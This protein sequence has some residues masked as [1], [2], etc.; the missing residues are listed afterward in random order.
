MNPRSYYLSLELRD[1]T[2]IPFKPASE[3]DK[4]DIQEGQIILDYGCGIGSFTLP[5]AKLV[6]EKGKVYALDKDPYALKRVKE[7]AEK[8]GLHNIDTILSDRETGL[9]DESL[10]VILL[11]GVLPEVKDRHPLLK[12]LHRVLKPNGHL[13]TRYC[14]RLKK[15][16]VL[17]IMDETGLYSLRE[18]K[19]HIL[20]YERKT[21]AGL[22]V[23]LG[24]GKKCKAEHEGEGKDHSIQKS[25]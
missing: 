7:K 1:K 21:E 25:D 16:E 20:N 13:S 24:T 5:V 14:F 17:R 12:E 6:G 19:G 11:I 15:K 3:M 4:L 18:Q 8:E 22:R 23:R 9:P 10:D 2:G